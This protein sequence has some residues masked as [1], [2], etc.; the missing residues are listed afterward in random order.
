ML[1]KR[2]RSHGIQCCMKGDNICKDRERGEGKEMRTHMC[3]L[4]MMSVDCNVPRPCT[5]EEQTSPETMKALR[6]KDWPPR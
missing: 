2:N 1:S 5:S 6:R 3:P 4:P